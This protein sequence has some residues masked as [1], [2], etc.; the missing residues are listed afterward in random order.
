M[1]AAIEISYSEAWGDCET[2]GSYDSRSLRVTLDDGSEILNAYNDGH[3]AGRVPD[4]QNPP[5]IIAAV[6]HGMGYR[7][8]VNGEPF[9]PAERDNG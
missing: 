4:I 3:L 6:L 8:T 1:T 2:C 9:T 7:V 5:E